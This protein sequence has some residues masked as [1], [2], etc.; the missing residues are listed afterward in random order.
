M[1]KFIPTKYGIIL[2]GES[3]ID[4]EFKRQA[5][6]PIHKQNCAVFQDEPCNCGLEWKVP[7]REAPVPAV[8]A[9]TSD[10]LEKIRMAVARGWCC[11]PNSTKTFD[12]TLAESITNEVRRAF[13][14]I[15]EER[16]SQVRSVPKT[17]GPSCKL[18]GVLLTAGETK[19]IS[20]PA[21]VCQ[22]CALRPDPTVKDP[23]RELGKEGK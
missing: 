22:K 16:Q 7:V 12:A 20:V 5:V 3:P 14:S 19:F 10:E 4:H 13:D 1:S 18:C 21:P 15:V 23:R 6:Q 11:G 2:G 9:P 8:V 17:E